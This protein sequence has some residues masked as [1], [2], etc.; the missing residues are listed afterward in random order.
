MASG[1]PSSAWHSDTTSSTDPASRPIRPCAS[2]ARSTKSRAVSSTGELAASDGTRYANS[3]GVPSASRLVARTRTPRAAAGDGDHDL[4]GPV[5][6]VLAVVDDHEPV[7]HPE[8]IDDRRDHPHPRPFPDAQRA[9]HWRRPRRRGRRRRPARPATPRRRNH[10]TRRHRTAGP[11]GSCRPRRPPSASPRGARPS[12]VAIS[13][14]SRIAADERRPVGRAGS[15]RRRPRS[16][17]AG[18][19]CAPTAGSSPRHR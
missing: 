17:R 18:G 3:P 4:G 14:N 11:G 6:D 1:I 7:A 19:R 8:R 16:A 12:T 15:S 2:A 13:A 5:E 10:P 9:R